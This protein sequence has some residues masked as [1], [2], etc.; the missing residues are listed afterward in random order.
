MKYGKKTK[1]G[2]SLSKGGK[3]RRD[4]PSTTSRWR[5]GFGKRTKTG[6]A[7]EGPV[8]DSTKQD[9][10]QNSPI[11]N[12]PVGR[13]RGDG[14]VHPR[15]DRCLNGSI[16][17]GLTVGVL[18]IRG[19]ARSVS[20]RKMGEEEEEEGKE[21]EEGGERRN[22]AAEENSHLVRIKRREM[23]ALFGLGWRLGGGLGGGG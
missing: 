13:F 18:R 8:K 6:G 7:R 14:I 11:A 9:S 1:E 17:D 12:V 19:G 20:G 3:T 15:I 21:E 5:R 4:H 23:L 16:R 22:A 10:E 2:E